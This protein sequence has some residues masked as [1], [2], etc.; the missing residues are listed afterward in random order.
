MD[1]LEAHR[2][3]WVSEQVAERDCEL[4]YLPSYSPHLNP[5]EEASAT[6]ENVLRQ[7][8]FVLAEAWRKR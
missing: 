2:P 3:K 4:I 8:S 7:A 1:N 6:I 5:L